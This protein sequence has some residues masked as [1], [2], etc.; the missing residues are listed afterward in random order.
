MCVRVSVCDTGL[1]IKQTNLK[2]KKKKA[3]QVLGADV[4]VN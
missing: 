1:E 3:A 2:K 4:E